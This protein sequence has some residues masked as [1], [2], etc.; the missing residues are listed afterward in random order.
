V[1]QRY[2]DLG[3]LTLR[4]FACATGARV[5]G[6]LL[7]HKPSRSALRSRLLDRLNSAQ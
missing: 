1:D 5:G 4:S 2:V 7:R 6:R 3:H